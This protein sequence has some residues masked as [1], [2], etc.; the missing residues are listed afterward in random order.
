[1]VTAA[2]ALSDPTRFELLSS[3]ARPCGTA[4]RVL[5]RAAVFF[6]APC[7]RFGLRRVFL[8]RAE[9]DRGPRRRRR[10]R[11]G[12]SGTTLL[13]PRAGNLLNGDSS[14]RIKFSATRVPILFGRAFLWRSVRTGSTSVHNGLSRYILK[15]AREQRRA[16][17]SCRTY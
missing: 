4:R 13:D 12:A 2:L 8:C 9:S 6:S 17:Q 15:G 14:W 5:P 7:P 11:R 1:M 10:R 3:A 16:A